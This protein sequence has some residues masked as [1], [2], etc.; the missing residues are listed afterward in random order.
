MDVLPEPMLHMTFVALTYGVSI[1]VLVD[2]L[3]EPD[4]E[5]DPANCVIVVFQ[6]LF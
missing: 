5:H 4:I 1:L 3:P 6:S 2:V